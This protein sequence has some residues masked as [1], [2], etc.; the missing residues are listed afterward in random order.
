M[1]T[2]LSTFLENISPQLAN[3]YSEENSLRYLRRLPDHL[4]TFFGD[5]ISELEERTIGTMQ[6]IE[7]EYN[8]FHLFIILNR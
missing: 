8:V 6:D 4:E 1:V 7:S 2:L 3:Y 5:I